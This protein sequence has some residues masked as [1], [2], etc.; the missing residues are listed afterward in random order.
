MKSQNTKVA[1]AGMRA[2]ARIG[3]RPSVDVKPPD[4]NS[5]SAADQTEFLDSALRYADAQVQQGN[6]EDA[7]KIYL[8]ALNR[9]EA[10]IQCAAI[11]GMAK[12]PAPQAVEAISTKLTSSSS[13]VRITAEKALAAL[14]KRRVG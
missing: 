3:K 14:K 11:I 7:G 4:L 6:L 9:E 8:F 10:H 12:V 5:L 1:M 13:Q 2:I